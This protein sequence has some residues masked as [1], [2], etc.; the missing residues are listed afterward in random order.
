[1][2][3]CIC[4]TAVSPYDFQDIVNKAGLAYVTF[5]RK[6]LK[7]KI[8]E[9][10]RFDKYIETSALSFSG[11]R[12][13]APGPMMNWILGPEFDIRQKRWRFHCME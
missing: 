2:G 6:D 5:D 8:E 3:C 10:M 4:S 1:M 7:N 11:T 12:R 13:H 9:K